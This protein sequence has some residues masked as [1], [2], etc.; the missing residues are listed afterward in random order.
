MNCPQCGGDLAGRDVCPQCGAQADADGFVN[1]Y[2]VGSQFRDPKPVLDAKPVLNDAP[3]EIPGFF[4]ALK[5]CF[6]EKYRSYKGRASRSEFWFSAFWLTLVWFVW[7]VILAAIVWPFLRSA[8]GT[9]AEP[10]GAGF[11]F[12]IA[13]HR[14]SAYAFALIFVPSVCVTARRLHDVGLPGWIGVPILL[15]FLPLFKG[16]AW[17]DV[18]DSTRDYY[19][20]GQS[21]Y[22]QDDSSL[23]TIDAVL[24]GAVVLLLI[25]FV[26]G[27]WQGT[28]LPNKYGPA[29]EKRPKER[30]GA[31]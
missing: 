18:M 11:V 30:R 1:P 16:L 2:A 7:T 6:W 27:T 26:V 20:Q 10:L 17:I 13:F 8:M 14:V 4:R 21:Y 5:I 9:Y 3:P 28:R 31:Q 15:A 19:T 23:L 24:I 25:V 22:I 29:P 12:R